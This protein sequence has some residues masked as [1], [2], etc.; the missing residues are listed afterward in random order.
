M[1]AFSK[2]A[3]CDFNVMNIKIIVEKPINLYG[4]YNACTNVRIENIIATENLICV[5]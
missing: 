4:A 5:T 1:Y 3:V 2:S